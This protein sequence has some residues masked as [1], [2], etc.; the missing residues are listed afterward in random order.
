[1]NHTIIKRDDK[2]LTRDGKSFD[3]ADAANAHSAATRATISER[4]GRSLSDSEWNMQQLPAAT[5]SRSFA[6]QADDEK[7]S[8]QRRDNLSPT[9]RLLAQTESEIER[10]RNPYAGMSREEARAHDLRSM[11]D[12]EAEAKLTAAAKAAH[13]KSQGPKLEVLNQLIADENFNPE[14]DQKFRELLHKAKLSLEEP[15]ADASEVARLFAAV[16]DVLIARQVNEQAGL[17]QEREQLEGKERRN[18]EQLLLT[19]PEPKKEHVPDPN[20][21]VDPMKDFVSES[22]PEPE[23]PKATID[24]SKNLKEQIFDL[25]NLA[26]ERDFPLENRKEIIA[27]E[28]SFKQ[29][30]EVPAMEAL[31]KY[32]D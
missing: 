6:E 10:K 3:T 24:Q 16:D 9:E 19:D 27:A 17:M 4:I 25:S 14:S 11:I 1:M 22:E 8:P 15:D 31:A 18:S 32:A 26:F 30:D 23:S 5:D 12:R 13:L 7:W 28:Q 21:Y 2:Y 29:D 20:G